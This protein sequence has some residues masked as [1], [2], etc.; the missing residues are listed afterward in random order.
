MAAKKNFFFKYFSKSP[1]KKSLQQLYTTIFFLPVLVISFIFVGILYNTL[2][3]WENQQVRNSLIQAENSLNEMLSTIKLF[4]DRIYVNKPL[5][6][7]VLQ[8]FATS[9]DAY[10]AYT[11]LTFLDDY[12][13]S[14]REVASF[15][16]YTEN[17][18]LLENS[19]IVKTTEAISREFWYEKAVRTKGQVFWM[20]KT[21]T[22]TKKQYLSLIRSVYSLGDNSFIGVL[23]VN[24]SPDHIVR[25]LKNQFF[26]SAI[27]YENQIIFSSEDNLS[28][29]DSQTLRNELV[30]QKNRKKDTISTIYWKG[31]RSGVMT[32]QFT[33]KT[34]S[35]SDFTLLYVIPVKELNR[36]TFHVLIP[37]ALI[38]IAIIFLSF[39]AIQIFNNYINYRVKIVRDEIQNV[40]ENNF[41]IPKTIGG[42]DEFE[43]IYHSLYLMSEKVSTLINQVYKHKLDREQ[44]ASRQNE[45]RYKMLATQINPHF[46]FNT[47]ETIRMKSLAS[48]DKEVATMLKLLAALLRYNLNVSGKTVP[49]YNELDA[50]QNYLNIQRYRFGSR[51]T[52]DII[53][54]CDVQKIT[55]LPLLIQPLVENSFSHGLESTVSGGFIYIMISEEEPEYGPTLL[56]VSVKDNGCG[57]PADKL[58]DLNQALKDQIVDEYEGSIGLMNVN[59]RIKLYYGNQ[60]GMEIESEEGKGTEVR[61]TFPLIGT[62]QVRNSRI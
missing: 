62:D 34:S 49:L 44:I 57:I 33:P 54:M 7:V 50:V 9:L 56:H 15:R 39:F 8:E 53:T 51:I 43:Q 25:T 36:V 37:T 41:S 21:D 38:L 48:G 3:N 47:L 13:Q 2:R 35:I 31:S 29:A 4:S 14:Y 18:T 28:Y 61:L 32:R 22:V 23:V 27:A 19:Y 17:M 40:V 6:D 11:N 1:I 52:Y 10:Y 5:Q 59:S 30:Y 24:V 55:I 42:M 45:I 58:R 46:L 26:E 16:L 12:L 60:F 20:Y